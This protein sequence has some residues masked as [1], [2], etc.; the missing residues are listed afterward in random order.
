MWA[1]DPLRAAR[2]A[3]LSGELSSLPLGLD[4]EDWAEL[5]VSGR[6]SPA[7][8]ADLRRSLSA[9]DAPLPE[10]PGYTKRALRDAIGA[11]D[12]EKLLELLPGGWEL[13]EEWDDPE[14]RSWPHRPRELAALASACGREVEELCHQLFCTTAKDDAALREFVKT[15]PK[16]QRSPTGH[17]QVQ[18]DA[19]RARGKH[20][21]SPDV[22]TNRK[23]ALDRMSELEALVARTGS[24]LVLRERLGS[25]R[26]NDWLRTIRQH[27]QDGRVSAELVE[28]LERLPDWTWDHR[29]A[30]D[31]AR[32]RQLAQKVAAS[33]KPPDKELE[34]MRRRVLAGDLHPQ[35]AAELESFSWWSRE[36]PG[37]ADLALL[38]RKLDYVRREYVLTDLEQDVIDERLYRPSADQTKLDDLGARR[39]LSREGV[40]LAE[41]RIL[42][43]AEHP[44]LLYRAQF[45]SEATPPED[46]GTDEG[47]DDLEEDPDAAFL[48]FVQSR[49]EA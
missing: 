49:G 28:R 43:R 15:P 33:E 37:E 19:V 41:L 48:A 24:A 7:T 8:W 46:P 2:N 22:N 36:S 23:V 26:A 44:A 32:V 45:P 29:L 47:W 14:V 3:L 40:R 42:A 1:T 18:R 6:V 4:F 31:R 27:H 16:E 9:T 10:L 17:A 34:R 35:A 30:F 20:L 25:V 12:L 13:I 39:G 11:A 5:E 38:R 21:A